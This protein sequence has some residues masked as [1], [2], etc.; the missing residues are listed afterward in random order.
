MDIE[1]EIRAEMGRKRLG[2]SEIADKT[3]INRKRISN[4]INGHRDLTVT[5]LVSIS[6]AMQVPAWELLRRAQEAPE[7]VA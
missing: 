3:G 1:S 2:P 7:R 6:A 5:E 4:S